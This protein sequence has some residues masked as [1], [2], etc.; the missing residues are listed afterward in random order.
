MGAAP[1]AEAGGGKK[2][3]GEPPA[4]SKAKAEDHGPG[5]VFAVVDADGKLQR[6]MYVDS[7]QR[8]GPGTYEV[9]FRRDVRKG[10]YLATVGGHGYEGAPPA[11]TVAVQGRANNPK[12]VLVATS[13]VTGASVNMGFH[14]LVVCPEGYA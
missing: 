8:L 11:G 9:I 3:N 14:L 10:V 1:K 4:H 13:A 7:V 5:Q 6:G 12:G 2:V